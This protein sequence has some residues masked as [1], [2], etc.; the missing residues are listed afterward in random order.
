MGAAATGAPLLPDGYVAGTLSLVQNV[1]TNLLAACIAQLSANTPGGAQRL[2]IQTDSTGPVYIGIQTTLGG[3]LATT[4]YGVCLDKAQSGYVAGAAKTYETTFPGSNIQIGD[5]W[6]LMT[7]SA[8]TIHVE[9][10]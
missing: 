7:V 9:I 3:V 2:S 8:G 6:V 10:S 1:P 4:N 5:I